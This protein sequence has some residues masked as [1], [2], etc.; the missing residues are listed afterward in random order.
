MGTVKQAYIKAIAN[1]ILELHADK[2]TED[3]ETNKRIIREFTD[4][5]SKTL[6]NRVAGY[7]TRKIKKMRRKN[8]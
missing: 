5:E 1:K 3:F 2:F 8:V 7:I 4:I 6:R